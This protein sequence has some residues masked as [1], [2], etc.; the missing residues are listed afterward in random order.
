[1][2][3]PAALPALT[4]RLK[5]EDADERVLAL[6]AVANIEGPEARAILAGSLRATDSIVSR[7]AAL[8]L[9]SAP[10]RDG[11]V[12]PFLLHMLDR[13]AYADDPT[14][15]GPLRELMDETSRKAAREDAV[16]QF[17]VSACQAAAELGD[18]DAIPRL[19]NLR[20]ADPSLKV[21]SAAIDALFD[22]GSS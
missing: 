2:G 4:A 10:Y 3:D 20:E 6:D 17:L 19:E 7:N 13:A 1:M 8:L 9:A 12:K 16:E 21:R 18:R 15:D 22:L 11:S 5:G 14:L